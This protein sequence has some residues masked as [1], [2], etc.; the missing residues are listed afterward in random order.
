[1]LGGYVYPRIPQNKSVRNRARTVRTRF[2]LC[3]HTSQNPTILQP[4][5]RHTHNYTG[6]ATFRPATHGLAKR[7]NTQDRHRS[8]QPNIPKSTHTHVSKIEVH[9]MKGIR[10]NK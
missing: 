2:I 1:M 10:I 7:I 5:I 8:D 4:R 3:L 9:N 6:Q